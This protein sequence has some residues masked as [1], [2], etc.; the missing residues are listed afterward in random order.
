MGAAGARG[1]IISAAVLA[2]T[3]LVVV[4]FGL[5]PSSDVFGNGQ[6]LAPISALFLMFASYFALP[7][8][9]SRLAS[10][11]QARTMFVY[12]TIVGLLM[13]TVIAINSPASYP[14]RLVNTDGLMQTSRHSMARSAIISKVAVNL[15]TA[16]APQP[17]RIRLVL[18]SSKN[19]ETSTDIQFLRSSLFAEEEAKA[20]FTTSTVSSCGAA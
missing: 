2:M 3:T 6:M 4:R 20:R 13:P 14:P 17:L 11:Q 12:A 5:S 18:S 16:A 8:S 1:L 15:Q 10:F 7:F 19:I 9:S